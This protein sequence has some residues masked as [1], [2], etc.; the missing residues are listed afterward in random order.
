MLFACCSPKRW[1]LHCLV[2]SQQKT[3]VLTV[4]WRGACT[5]PSKI[6]IKGNI[7]IIQLQ[8][9]CLAKPILTFFFSQFLWG[10]YPVFWFNFSKP[11]RIEPLPPSAADPWFQRNLRQERKE[12]R[13]E[14]QKKYTAEQQKCFVLWVSYVLRCVGGKLA[15]SVYASFLFDFPK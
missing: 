11:C 8:R 2:A 14:E 1:Y 7:F 15:F 6:A 4:F 10:G 3:L 9:F 12:L 13:A 5:N